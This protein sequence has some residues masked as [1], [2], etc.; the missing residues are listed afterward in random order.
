MNRRITN[1]FS[2]IFYW[3]LEKFLRDIGEC[4]VDLGYKNWAIVRPPNFGL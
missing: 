2:K 4:V 1:N 3:C